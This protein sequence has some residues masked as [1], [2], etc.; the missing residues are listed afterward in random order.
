MHKKDKKIKSNHEKRRNRRKNC[1][2][3]RDSAYRGHVGSRFHRDTNTTE[4]DEFLIHHHRDV[5]R[6][7]ES[8]RVV[9]ISAL[10]SPC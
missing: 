7:G 6:E 1:V 10:W 5:K 9:Y 3:N 2:F 8:S 4:R